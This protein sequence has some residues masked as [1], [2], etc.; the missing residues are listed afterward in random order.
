MTARREL[1]PL[2]P[3]PEP[4]ELPG[5]DRLLAAHP[6]LGP[7]LEAAAP[8][9]AEE[10]QMAWHVVQSIYGHFATNAPSRDGLIIDLRAVAQL[11]DERPPRSGSDTTGGREAR[12]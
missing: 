3:I 6:D 7:R 4:P 10:R 8:T 9:M 5:L 1:P 12:R 2:P 11:L